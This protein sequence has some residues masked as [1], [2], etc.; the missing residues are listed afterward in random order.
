[1]S[2]SGIVKSSYHSPHIYFIFSK[3]VIYIGETQVIPVRRWSSHLDKSGSFSKKLVKH[4]DGGKQLGYLASL[5][6]YSISCHGLLG[7][8]E[9]NYCGYRIPTQALEH[10]IHEI[11][12][13]NSLFGTNKK[14]IS[15]TIKT[16]P[17]HFDHWDEIE[18][19]AMTCVNRII[20]LRQDDGVSVYSL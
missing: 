12:L 18:E 10:K 2:G 16:K 19:I 11:V 1:M 9:K 15:E 14:V 6:F 7:S 17:K 20:N 13:S 5:S 4:L 3:E 8:M